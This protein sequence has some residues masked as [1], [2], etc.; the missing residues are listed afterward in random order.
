MGPLEPGEVSLGSF[1]GARPGRPTG[2]SGLGETSVQP[3]TFHPTEPEFV[4]FGGSGPRFSPKS[5][6]CEPGPAI[7]LSAP[8]AQNLVLS[9]S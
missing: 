7:F 8:F 5:E 2:R 6:L 9:W 4:V 1:L 3:A